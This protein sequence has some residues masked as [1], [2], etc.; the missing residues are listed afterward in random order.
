VA[1]FLRDRLVDLPDREVTQ[2]LAT[3][4]MTSEKSLDVTA[5]AP[6]G[7]RRKAPVV[8]HVGGKLVNEILIPG[9][10][11]HLQAAQEPQ[12]PRS[13]QDEVPLDLL[14]VL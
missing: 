5:F 3:F 10:G 9:G 13:G 14:G 1:Q 4:A 2:L 12:P 7:H 8:F 6:D 11:R